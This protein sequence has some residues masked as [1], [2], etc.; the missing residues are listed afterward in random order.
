MIM[1]I[2]RSN[3]KQIEPWAQAMIPRANEGVANDERRATNILI[4]FSI[5]DEQRLELGEVNLSKHRIFFI[6]R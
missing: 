2:E 5:D 3:V 4:T 1:F 6:F